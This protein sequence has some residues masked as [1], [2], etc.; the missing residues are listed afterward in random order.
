MKF[1]RTIFYAGALALFPLA[2][3]GQTNSWQL[4]PRASVDSAGVFL[5]EIITAPSGVPHL[6]LTR[7]PSLGQTATFSRSQIADFVQRNAPSLSAANVSGA[8]QV[9]VT[10]R[11]R[12]FEE[13]D[14]VDLLTATLQKEFVKGRGEL[15][16]H[17]TRPWGR[18]QV[19]DEP[20]SLKVGELPAAGIVPNFVVDFVLWNG[21]ERVGNWQVAVQA[22]IWHDIPVAHSTLQ[23]GELLKDADVS[24][25][26]GDL[27]VQ[28]DVFPNFPTT[29]TALEL[30]ETVAAG[31]PILNRSVRVRPLIRRG[32]MVEAIFQDGTLGIS[33]MVESLQDGLCGQMVRVRNPKTQR[34]LDGKVE[35]EKT[36]RIIL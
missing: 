17:L 33:L 16:L 27:L 24:M 8:G 29:D 21:K 34:E 25:E 1:I 9:G 23:R 36:I 5:D 2:L 19:P 31:K 4:L 14:L 3:A 12:F 15:E 32:Q 11:I 35:N 28:R 7:A 10:R 30:S 22:A 26:R 20:L 6:R 18:P 13:S